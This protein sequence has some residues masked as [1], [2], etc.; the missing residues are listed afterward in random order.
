[1]LE[2]RRFFCC[3]RTTALM[4]DARRRAEN[5]RLAAE[6]QAA[7]LSAQL[8][9]EAGRELDGLVDALS[10]GKILE[11]ANRSERCDH[12]VP[13]NQSAVFPANDHRQY[14][15]EEPREPDA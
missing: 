11:E 6:A 9:F 15:R 5:Q 2:L 8:Q 12:A 7:G 1:M 10:G 3:W 13:G 4:I 14:I